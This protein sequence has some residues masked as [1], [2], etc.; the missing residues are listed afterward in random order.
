MCYNRDQ[1]ALNTRAQN[2]QLTRNRETQ[3]AHIKRQSSLNNTISDILI[4]P[5]AA[6]LIS[7]DNQTIVDHIQEA[8][9]SIL[10]KATGIR[11]TS[12]LI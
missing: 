11:Y 10:T 12:V 7:M 3:N 9:S 1:T 6:Q 8:K 2:T 5:I 4:S